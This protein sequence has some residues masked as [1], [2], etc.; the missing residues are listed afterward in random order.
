VDLREVLKEFKIG[1]AGITKKENLIEHFITELS[2]GT[3]TKASKEFSAILRSPSKSKS[4]TFSPRKSP[5][6]S[7]PE[8]Y[9]SKGDGVHVKPKPSLSA[10]TP[11]V[12]SPLQIPQS[13]LDCSLGNETP[14]GSAQ[15]RK[16]IKPLRISGTD[17]EEELTLNRRIEVSHSWQK[18]LFITPAKLEFTLQVHSPGS[19]IL[20]EIAD[21]S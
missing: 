6:N 18:P 1:C 19:I 7:S 5:D 2:L 12:E 17:S 13:P 8:M 11:N 16:D 10:A 4:G 3:N 15:P 14:Y 9:Q 21:T 20:R